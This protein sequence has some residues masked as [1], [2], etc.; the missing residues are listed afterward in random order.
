MSNPYVRDTDGGI[1][2]T[3]DKTNGVIETDNGSNLNVE[4]GGTVTDS[5][6]NY[7]GRIDS[8]GRIQ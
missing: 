1:V 5:D 4:A 3:W 7:V 8:D 2:G 6:G